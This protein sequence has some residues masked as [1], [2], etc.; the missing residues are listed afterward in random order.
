[1]NAKLEQF[2]SKIS[3]NSNNKRKFDELLY[4]NFDTQKSL[5]RI[6]AYAK[7]KGFDF[8]IEE[9]KELDDTPEDFSEKQTAFVRSLSYDYEYPKFL[10]MS[11]DYETLKRCIL[12]F[13]EELEVEI[14]EHCLTEEDMRE[15]KENLI[16]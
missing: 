5:E 9:I 14:C 16:G 3:D 6:Q 15:L 2:L 8:T 1:M 4:K 7:K 12:D 10:Q 11:V 13:A